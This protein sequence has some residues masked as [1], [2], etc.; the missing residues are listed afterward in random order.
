MLKQQQESISNAS[1]SLI[2]EITA[3]VFL[4]SSKKQPIFILCDK[5]YWCATYMDNTRLA[6]DSICPRCNAY[7]DS[8]H[9]N[10]NCNCNRELSSIPIMPNESFTFNCNA[11][12]GVELEFK[13][14]H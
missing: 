3:G 10:N 8:H 6:A 11:K 5:C 4:Q 13:P 2:A 14:R 1:S 12:R 9:D 7:S